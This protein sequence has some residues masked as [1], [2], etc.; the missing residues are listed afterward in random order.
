MISTG[1]FGGGAG[2]FSPTL[3]EEVAELPQVGASSPLRFN[4]AEFDGSSKFFV[5]VA[6]TTRSTSSSTSTAEDGRRATSSRPDRHRGL[7]GRRRRQQLAAREHR[8]PSGSRTERTDLTVEDDL[9][10][11]AARGSHRLRLLDRHVQRALHEP[12]RPAGLRQA[13]RRGQPGRG[14]DGRSTARSSRT[15]TPSSR[16]AREFKE[17]QAEHDQPAPEPDLRVALP[18]RPHRAHRH[19]EHAGALDLRA[20]A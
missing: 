12:A 11:R 10:Q 5:G 1:G 3:A 19:R 15:P 8:C 17:A 9:R 14:A 7:A 4:E 6:A 13:G 20:H 2:G 16:T 18:G